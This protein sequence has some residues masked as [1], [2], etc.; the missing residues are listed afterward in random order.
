MNAERAVKAFA[1]FGYDFNNAVRQ[2][3]AIGIAE[4]ENVGA[5]VLGGFNGAQRESRVGVIAIEEMFRVV[6]HFSAVVAQILY[7]F[8]NDFQVLVFA[9]LEGP[10]YVQVPA[11]AENGDGRSFRFN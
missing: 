9:D 11:L 10:M 8:R 3:A 6:D 5:G 2:V 1:D 7:G 4:T